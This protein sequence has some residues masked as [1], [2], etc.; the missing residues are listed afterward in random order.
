MILTRAITNKFYL[1]HSKNSWAKYKYR[2]CN[3]RSLL[4]QSTWQSLASTGISLNETL[5][6][7]VYFTNFTTPPILE[8]QGKCWHSLFTIKNHMA[9]EGQIFYQILTESTVMDIAFGISPPWW[10]NI[11]QKINIIGI[12]IK[13]LLMVRTTSSI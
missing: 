6:I 11:L 13:I 3:L 12:E 4:Y 9:K 10:Y 5:C 1:L 2:E 8:Q 7:R